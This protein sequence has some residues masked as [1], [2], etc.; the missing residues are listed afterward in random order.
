MFI[1]KFYIILRM[2]IG[3][4]EITNSEFYFNDGKKT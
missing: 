3:Q 2:G 4:V 1:E